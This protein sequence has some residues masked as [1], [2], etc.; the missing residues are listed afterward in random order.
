[1]KIFIGRRRQEA[2]IIC[3]EAA[4]PHFSGLVFMFHMDID[5]VAQ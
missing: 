5:Q 4:Q 2:Q 3:I 1:M